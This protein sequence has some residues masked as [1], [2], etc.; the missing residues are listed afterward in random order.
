MK[1]HFKRI[2]LFMASII[3]AFSLVGCA[4]KP[5]AT[6]KSFL[7]AVK[8]QDLSKASTLIK[9]EGSKEEFKYDSIEQE[10]MIKAIFSKIDYTLDKTTKNGDSATVKAKITSVDLTRVTTKM[11]SELFPT[12]MAQAFSAEKPDEQKQN[13]MMLQY[14]VNSIKDPNAPKTETEVDIKLTKDKSGWLIVPTEDLTNAMTG[15]FNT[16]AAALGGK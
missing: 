14:M 12:L 2:V 5:D 7:D 1:K 4:A 8:Q 11:V 9:K 6:A 10:K 15:N 3:L 13:D 16:A